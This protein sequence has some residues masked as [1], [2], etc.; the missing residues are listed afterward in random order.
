[1][2]L[3]WSRIGISYDG[4][5]QAPVR[6]DLKITPDGIAQAGGSDMFE[7]I[8]AANGTSGLERYCALLKRKGILGRE[9]RSNPA[10]GIY[11]SDTGEIM[12][13]VKSAEMTVRT[14]RLE[15]AVVK[16]GRP[17]AIDALTIE[18]STV[19]AAVTAVSLT[20]APLRNSRRILVVIATDARNSNMRF[21][22]ENEPIITIKCIYQIPCF[23]FFN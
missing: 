13:N 1:M 23:T 18:C 8:K 9:N 15:G 21:S 7:E 11:E 16:S 22:D 10:R 6:A 19:P 5:Y 2:E 3:I 14:P 20:D 17:V 12:M 4:R